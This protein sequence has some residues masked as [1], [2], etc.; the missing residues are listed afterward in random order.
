MFYS[1]I[2]DVI[3]VLPFNIYFYSFEYR[4]M[5]PK[6]NTGGKAGKS[7]GSEEGGKGEKAEKKGGTTVKVCLYMYMCVYI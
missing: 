5:P 4:R 1:M 6:K 2:D 3:R 7:K